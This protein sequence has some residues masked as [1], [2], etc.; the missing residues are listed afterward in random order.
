MSLYI[1]AAYGICFGVM[2]D[3]APLIPKLRKID[4]FN[5]MFSCAYCTGF[6]CGW[7]VWLLHGLIEGF[8]VEYVGVGAQA[9]AWAF[10]CGISCYLIDVT[11]RW[12][13]LSTPP[14]K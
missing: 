4:F 5:Q 14:E 1:L 9:I 13:E 2:N 10:A 8:P 12:V 11:S 3:R 7:F 6:H